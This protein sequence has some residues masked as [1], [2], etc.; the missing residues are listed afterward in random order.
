M[1]GDQDVHLWVS[2]F[3]VEYADW[4]Q[5][6]EL[7]GQR[8]TAG[9]QIHLVVHSHDSV[10]HRQTKTD[11]EDYAQLLQPTHLLDQTIVLAGILL[12]EGPNA[13]SAVAGRARVNSHIDDCKHVMEA[14]G[15]RSE[16]L[17]NAIRGCTALLAQCAQAKQVDPVAWCLKLKQELTSAVD[18][19]QSMLNAALDEAGIESMRGAL[20]NAG[21]VVEVPGKLM[22]ER[23]ALGWIINGRWGRV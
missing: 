8:T 21:A 2:N 19:S 23:G 10:I 16:I 11:L 18:R 17:I 14:R 20:G 5:V 4:K 9:A 1:S 7:I 13:P 6:F 12:H 22:T 15:Q 3:G